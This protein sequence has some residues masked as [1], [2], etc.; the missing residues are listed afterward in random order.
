MDTSPIKEN[1]PEPRIFRVHSEVYA[2]LYSDLLALIGPAN[3]L[4]FDLDLLVH[5]LANMVRDL[6]EG[7]LNLVIDI[8]VKADRHAIR[9]HSC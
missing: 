7:H 4:E 1:R 5:L 9:Q 2:V 8:D 3:L 6:L